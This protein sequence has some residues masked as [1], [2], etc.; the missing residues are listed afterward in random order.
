[1]LDDSP[2]K[3]LVIN[4]WLFQDIKGENGQ[5]KRRETARFLTQ[6]AQGRDKFAALNGKPWITKVYELM[7][8]STPDIRR[9]SKLVRSLIIDPS[10]C[11]IL[12]PDDVT[13]A[14]PQDAIA[15][16]PE[17]DV[18]L[19]QTY[20]A[21]GADLLVTTDEGLLDAFESREDVQVVHRDDFLK[22]YL[23]S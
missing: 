19:I 9:L 2:T 22:N 14:A 3:L 20:Y 1:M 18:Y 8:H 11:V 4:E 17:E 23:S 15:A 6:F 16:A 7:T 10:K 13:D 5:S 21:A 12:Q